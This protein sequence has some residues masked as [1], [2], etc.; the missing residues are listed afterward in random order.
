MVYLNILHHEVKLLYVE[1]LE[2]LFLLTSHAANF[3]LLERK[4]EQ[5]NKAFL[6]AAMFA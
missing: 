6:R 2:N 5:C 1:K 3:V 4:F